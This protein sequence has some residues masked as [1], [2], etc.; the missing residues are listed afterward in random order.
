M[1]TLIL[2]LDE[3]ESLSIE[4]RRPLPHDR[5]PP[6]NLQGIVTSDLPSHNKVHMEVDPICTATKEARS[7]KEDLCETTQSNCPTT[8][9]SSGIRCFEKLV[10]ENF[11]TSSDKF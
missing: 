6:S 4:Y 3:Q 10:E 11:N 8:S 1:E 5:G 9:F 2:Q 7:F